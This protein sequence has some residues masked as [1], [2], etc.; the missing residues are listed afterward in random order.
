MILYEKPRETVSPQSVMGEIQNNSPAT[1][2]LQQDSLQGE[3]RVVEGPNVIFNVF[4]R[5]EEIGKFCLQLNFYLSS[6]VL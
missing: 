2:H 6:L 5:T 3:L 1:G 4:V